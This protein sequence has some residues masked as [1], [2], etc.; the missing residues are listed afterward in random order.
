[1]AN[2]V[3]TVFRDVYDLSFQVSPIILNGGSASGALGGMLPILGLLSELVGT[4]QGVL[5]S[6]LD[7]AD[8][9]F[10]FLPIPGGTLINNAVGTYPFANQ[11]VAAN[12]IIEQPRNISLLMIANLS[13]I[14]TRRTSIF[15]NCRSFRRCAR[16]TS[17]HIQI[18]RLRCRYITTIASTGLRHTGKCTA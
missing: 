14:G 10:R 6:G 1:M 16:R 11:Q 13:A 9:P 5:T 4:A 7:M 3:S 2:T 18:C 12:A 17:L 8:F 15:Q